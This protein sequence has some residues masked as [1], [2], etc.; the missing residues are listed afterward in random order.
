VIERHDLTDEEWAQLASLLPANPGRGGRW[1]DHRRTINGILFRT[2]TG[3]PWRDL[4]PC[5]GHWLTTYK[6]H[7]R[8]SGDGTW[9]QILEELRAGCDAAEGAGWTVSIDSTV[10][11]AHQHAAGARKT[12]PAARQHT[13]GGGE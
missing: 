5:Y 13:G 8:W 4:P 6:R 7:R 9:A 1:A 12:A 10:V 3:C 11:R 2:R